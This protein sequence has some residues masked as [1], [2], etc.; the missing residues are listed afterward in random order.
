MAEVRDMPKAAE[1]SRT[2]RP[3]GPL[4]PPGIRASV[5]ECGCPLSSLAEN[6]AAEHSG[7]LVLLGT[8]V[9]VGGP[10]TLGYAAWVCPGPAWRIAF[11]TTPR[12]PAGASRPPGFPAP[13]VH[14]RLG[15][16][17]PPASPPGC[18]PA[19]TSAWKSQGIG[20]SL[21]FNGQDRQLLRRSEER[22]V[23]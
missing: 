15:P 4:R 21:F 18:W 9:G 5:L 12:F 16:K 22:R 13:D 10:S 23:G 7:A 3:G 11:G 20:P 2:P 14:R 8:S 1:D 17:I 19:A 6:R